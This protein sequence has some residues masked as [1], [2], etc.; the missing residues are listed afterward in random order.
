M[1]LRAL[2]LPMV[3]AFAF[4][5]Q[6]QFSILFVDD[7]E[8]NFENA[9]RFN[10]SVLDA[11]YTTTY[12]D[13]EI[14]GA[15][16]TALYMEEFDLVIWHTAG[17]GAGLQFWNAD[18]TDNQEIVSFLESG[19]KLWVVG[20][21][22]LFDRYGASPVIFEPGDF[23]FNYLGI[24]SY[25]VQSQSDDG[26]LGVPSVAP[27]ENSPIPN[28]NSLNWEFETLW[29]VDGVTPREGVAPVYRMSGED[30]PLADEICGTYRIGQGY[31]VLAYYFDISVTETA[32]MRLENVEAALAFLENI[33]LSVEDE[34]NFAE[35]L[36]IYP[37]PNRGN[38][39]LEFN[40]SENKPIS[41]SL[42]DATGRE[43]LALFP[44]R[45]FAA[46]KN[47]LELESSKSVNPGVYFIQLISDRHT[48][49][50]PVIIE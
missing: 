48:E 21:D 4:N 43:I 29:W 20:L 11:G 6:A 5:L 37:N 45:Q 27:D 3:M 13:A 39:T 10:Q 16:P 46:G 36:K 35:N 38:F 14:E 1:S 15:S 2:L 19:G 8:D 47:I 50:F 44:E 32:D 49:A 26:G 7:T 23:A 17:D 30:Y 41:G 31:V 9:E 25:N 40:L 33:N 24:E 22:F 12:Y 28:L 34:F 18:D 42:I